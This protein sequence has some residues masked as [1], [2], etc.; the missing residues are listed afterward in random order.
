MTG[1]LRYLGNFLLGCAM[2]LAF[3]VFVYLVLEMH[4]AIWDFHGGLL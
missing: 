2:F 3:C 4:T 1:L